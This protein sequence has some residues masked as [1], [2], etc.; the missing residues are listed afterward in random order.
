MGLRKR[1]QAEKEE[2]TPADREMPAER[3]IDV[4][5]W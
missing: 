1:R 3:M 4:E 5:F 2:K